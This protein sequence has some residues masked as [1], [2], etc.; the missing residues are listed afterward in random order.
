MAALQ[1]GRQP[2]QRPDFR[3]GKRRGGRDCDNPYRLSPKPE[4]VS[5]TSFSIDSTANCRIVRQ[6]DAKAHAPDMVAQ[7]RPGARPALLAHS[8]RARQRHPRG[9]AGRSEE[10]TSELQSLMRISYAV[11]CL[12]KKK[13][14]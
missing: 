7:P 5:F 4:G 13:T 6:R 11:F 1:L 12:N 9:P 3:R 8:C 2:R 10:H 14:K